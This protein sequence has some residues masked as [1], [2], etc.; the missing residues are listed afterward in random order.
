MA[1]PIN[2]VCF[3]MIIRVCQMCIRLFLSVYELS[4][5]ARICKNCDIC[6]TLVSVFEKNANNR[7]ARADS[8][9]S[10][11]KRKDVRPPWPR[12]LAPYRRSD[13]R[14]IFRRSRSPQ[15]ARLLRIFLSIPVASTA[16]VV[17]VRFD[18]RS[19]N[20]VVEC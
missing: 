3:S 17:I 15:G 9:P 2:T 14:E 1:R 20:V 4:V 16:E 13:G 19:S 11:T 12:R 10:A 7:R 8:E 5:N 6:E 18:R